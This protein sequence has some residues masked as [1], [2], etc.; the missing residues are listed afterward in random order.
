M[1]NQKLVGDVAGRILVVKPA[2]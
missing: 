2:R 1:A